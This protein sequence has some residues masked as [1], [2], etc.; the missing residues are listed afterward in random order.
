[1]TE[2]KFTINQI[3]AHKTKKAVEV[4][5]R[6]RAELSRAGLPANLHKQV[7]AARRRPEKPKKPSQYQRNPQP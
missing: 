5:R 1:M 3:K 7:E 2:R 4:E 6:V